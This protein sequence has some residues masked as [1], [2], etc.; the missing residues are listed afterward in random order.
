MS[1][2]P[3]LGILVALLLSSTFASHAATGDAAELTDRYHDYHVCMDR[4]LGKLWEE[5]YG[6]ELARN[7]WGAVEATG[8][9]ID[10]SPQVVRVTDLR[11]RRERNLAGEPRP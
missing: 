10:T 3:R 6:I 9:A 7:R 8:A 1:I 5:R 11:C 4:A 2:F